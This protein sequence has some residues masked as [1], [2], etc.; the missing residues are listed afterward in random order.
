MIYRRSLLQAAQ[1]TKRRSDEETAL[2][3][4]TCESFNVVSFIVGV[5]GERSIGSSNG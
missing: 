1:C 3:I 4:V 5:G 2:V